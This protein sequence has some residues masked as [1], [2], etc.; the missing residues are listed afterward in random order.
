MIS[1]INNISNFL[2]EINKSRN[3]F[4]SNFNFIWDFDIKKIYHFLDT[5]TFQQEGALF[6]IVILLT[7]LLIVFN[8]LGVFFGNE[9]IKYFNIEKKFPKLNKFFK[10]RANLQ[11][12]YLMW[13]IFLLFVLCIFGIGINI[14]VFIAG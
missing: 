4:I 7:I 10:L 6:H 5:L 13:N 12:Y 14:L 11:R 8:I 9:L 3:N 1:N 2:D